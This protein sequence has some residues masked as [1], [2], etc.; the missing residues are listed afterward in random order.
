MYSNQGL[1][2][3]SPTKFKVFLGLLHS[4]I[5]GQFKPFLPVYHSIAYS[6]T[7]TQVKDALIWGIHA[8]HLLIKWSKQFFYPLYSNC[9]MKF[10]QS[11]SLVTSTFLYT[12]I[13]GMFH[14]RQIPNFSRPSTLFSKQFEDFFSFQNSRTL[15]KAGLEFKA[16]EPCPMFFFTFT[17]FSLL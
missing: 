16:G 3:R 13:G 4:I 17:S 15:F 14:D 7:G 2:A 9:G 6:S 5:R 12:L 11:P 1:C 8:W 10:A